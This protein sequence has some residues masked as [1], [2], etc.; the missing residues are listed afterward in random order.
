MAANGTAC[1]RDAVPE[2]GFDFFFT[3]C[4]RFM[5]NSASVIPCAVNFR[6]GLPFRR[7]S[8]GE[9]G[10]VW[11]GKKVFPSQSVP[12]STGHRRATVVAVARPVQAITHTGRFN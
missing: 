4:L 10:E 3:R 8:S 7:G 2:L 9:G 11:G 5:L 1:F 6:V 12:G